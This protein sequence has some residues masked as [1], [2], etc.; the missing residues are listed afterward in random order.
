MTAPNQT[1]R[2]RK[3]ERKLTSQRLQHRSVAE[4]HAR[5]LS[6]PTHAGNTS[7]KRN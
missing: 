3:N 5:P 1:G 6:A 4:L 2:G 7:Y